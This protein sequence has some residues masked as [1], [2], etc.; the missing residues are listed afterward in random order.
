MGGSDLIALGAIRAAR[1]AGLTVPGLF[2]LPA[3]AD[4]VG[5]GAT[6]AANSLARSAGLSFIVLGTA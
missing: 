1:R 4:C 5:L 6:G 2:W 3:V